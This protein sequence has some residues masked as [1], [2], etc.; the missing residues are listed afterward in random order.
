MDFDEGVKTSR[1]QFHDL[2][3]MVAGFKAPT[4]KLVDLLPIKKLQ[5]VESPNGFTLVTRARH[6]ITNGR[7]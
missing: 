6:P 2:V 3:F 4:E 1:A 7:S 5:P